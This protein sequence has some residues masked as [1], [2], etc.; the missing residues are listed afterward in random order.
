MEQIREFDYVTG[1]E[2]STPPTSGTPSADADLVTKGYADDTYTRLDNVLGTTDTIANLRAF[3]STDADRVDDQI[4]VVVGTGATYAWDSAS[5]ATDDGDA[6]V[7]PNDNPVTGRW[8]KISSGGGGGGAAG[9]SGIEQLMQKLENEHSNVLTEDLDKSVGVSGQ[10]KPVQ[11]SFVM[12]LLQ[13]QSASDTSIIAVM[14]AKTPSDSDPNM[15]STTGWSAVNAGSNLTA[16]TTAG[17]FKIGSAALKFD[18]DNSATRAAIRYDRGVQDLGLGLNTRAYAMVK[19]PSTTNLTDVLLRIYSDTTSNYREFTAAT[20]ASG[21]SLV[22][23]WNL[24]FWDLTAA[25][26]VG[27]SGWAPQSDMARYIECGVNT[28]S[29]GQTYTGIIFDSLSFSHR[30]PEELGVVGSKWTI[31]DDSNQEG[32]TIDSTNTTHDGTLSLTSGLVAAYAGGFS[33]SAASKIKRSSVEIAGGIIPMD[34]D[35]GLSGAVVLSQQLRLGRVLRGTISGSA[36]AFADSVAVQM[37]KVKTVGGSTIDIEDSSDTH[38]DLLNGNTIEIY[39]P[40]FVEGKTQYVF[41]FSRNLTANSSYSAGLTTLTLTT[42]SILAGDIACKRHVTGAKVSLVGVSSNESMSSMT[43]ENDPDGVQLIQS[44]SGLV[45]VNSCYGDWLLGASSQVEALKNQLASGPSFSPTGTINYSTDGPFGESA[46][47]GFSG[48]P[49]FLSIATALSYEM[50]PAVASRVQLS[51]WF[52]DNIGF[53]GS[54]RAILARVNAAFT[55]GWYVYLDGTSNVINVNTDGVL[56]YTS[57]S[58]ASGKWNHLFVRLEN[59]ASNAKV[60][61]NGVGGSA[62]TMVCSTAASPF[63]VGVDKNTGQDPATSVDLYGL[64]AWSGG[65]QLTDSEIL[66]LAK[67]PRVRAIQRYMWKLAGQ[68][69]QKLGLEIS[70]NRSTSAIQPKLMKAGCMIA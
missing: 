60:W 52:R 14:N 9:G 55:A 18:K 40:Y 46:A 63:Y 32:I 48:A 36:K 5:T 66:T 27:G 47:T 1:I 13:G 4:I 8:L 53:N 62:F 64:R 42:T 58:Y 59:G 12:N 17:E 20:N 49:N 24:V 43:L 65:P 30:Y 33:G 10:F 56:Q 67:T 22:T 54:G 28:S 61:L 19:L 15:D 7:K 31:H 57:P 29:A 38:L 11:K 41:L 3:L 25:G 21:G 35:S 44:G 68:S 6:V 69:G 39:R 51:L 37:Y 16:T 23:G 34:N 50:D 26:S 2:T 45:K 70:M